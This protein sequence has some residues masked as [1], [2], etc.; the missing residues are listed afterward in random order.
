MHC[1]LVHCLLLLEL[2]FQIQIHLNF[3]TISISIQKNS[4]TEK[5]KRK[6][7]EGQ[8]K[9]PAQADRLGPANPAPRSPRLGPGPAKHRLPLLPG[10]RAGPTRGS[11][12]LSP[13]LANR[14]ARAR[15]P[16]TAR[17]RRSDP[18]PFSRRDPRPPAFLSA[19]PRRRPSKGSF[20]RT[21]TRSLP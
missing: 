18:S 11:A 8:A 7:R 21:L 16:L 17:P 4:K 10:L 12:S 3:R 5:R 15:L 9:R 1:M 6:K 2:R 13:H 14:R 20:L 19:R